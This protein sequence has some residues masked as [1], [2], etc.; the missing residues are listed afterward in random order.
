ML[1]YLET[2][3]LDY[4]KCFL[5]LEITFDFGIDIMFGT[6]DYLLSA[7]GVDFFGLLQGWVVVLFTLTIEIRSLMSW[8]EFLVY[9]SFHSIFVY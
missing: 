4:F 9:I 6:W 3:E 1:I 8:L 7:V 5:N 2:F